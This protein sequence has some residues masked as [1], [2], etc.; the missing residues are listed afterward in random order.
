VQKKTKPKYFI[1]PLKFD[2]LQVQL[3]FAVT[4]R[5]KHPVVIS[6]WHAI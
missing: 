2:F 3:K 1:V 4:I 5:P 6:S